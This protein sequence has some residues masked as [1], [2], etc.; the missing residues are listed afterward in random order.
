MPSRPVPALVM[1]AFS[2]CILSPL[3]GRPEVA[4]F[5][6]EAGAVGTGT[7][8]AA[9]IRRP[10]ALRVADWAFQS[11][12][13][14][15]KMFFR[16]ETGAAAAPGSN[17]AGPRI[18]DIVATISATIRTSSEEWGKHEQVQDRG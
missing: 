8:A 17:G 16:R 5:K 2:G 10:A 11:R 7:F 3:S 6:H 18:P 15:L 14:R 13:F 1:P 12:H 4:A 9:L